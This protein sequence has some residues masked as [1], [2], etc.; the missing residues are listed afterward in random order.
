MDFMLHVEIYFYSAYLENI[1]QCTKKLKSVTIEQN[2]TLVYFKKTLY[3]V[4]NG[5]KQRYAIYTICLHMFSPL[6]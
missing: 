5:H 2:E 6:L 4:T 3:S 1:I